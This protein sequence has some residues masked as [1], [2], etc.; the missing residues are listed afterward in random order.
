[1]EQA[2]DARQDLSARPA[3]SDVCA[4]GFGKLGKTRR[5]GK[6]S[7]RE[8]QW[9]YCR[10]CSQR[11]TTKRVKRWHASELFLVLHAREE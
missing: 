9:L 6:E 3:A 7:S 4:V 1:M 5:V 2:G 8:R 11:G 10:I